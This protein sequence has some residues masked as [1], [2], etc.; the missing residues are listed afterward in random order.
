[1]TSRS[2]MHQ[3]LA[4]KRRIDATPPGM[5]YL[6]G[7]GPTGT[8]CEQCSFYGF[9]IQHPNSCYRYY[10]MVSEHAAAFPAETPSCK[11]FTPRSR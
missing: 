4:L 8:V 7:T 1:M 10:L 11:H 6:S 9:H 3:A 2:L 5:A